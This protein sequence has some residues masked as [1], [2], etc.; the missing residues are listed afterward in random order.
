M[1][2]QRTQKQQ[3]NSVIYIITQSIASTSFSLT[4]SS[5]KKTISDK[6][7]SNAIR[8]MFTGNLRTNSIHE[9]VKSVNTYENENNS[10]S[11]RCSSRQDKAGI[12][13]PPSIFEN[14]YAIL[15]I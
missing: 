10:K 15:V 9:G 4:R 7:V 12:I 8:I 13:F 11:I 14:F 1:G 2:L 6:E 5:N 3:L